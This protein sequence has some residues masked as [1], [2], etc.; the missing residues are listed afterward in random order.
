MMENRFSWLKKLSG[1]KLGII[2]IALIIIVALGIFV[3]AINSGGEDVIGVVEIH[4]VSRGDIELTIHASGIIAPIERREITALVGGNIIYSPFDEGDTVR[5]GDV[6]FR[7][8]DTDARLLAQRMA[9]G[10]EGAALQAQVTAQNVGRL[11]I[12]APATGI[13]S[14]FN[15]N[16]GDPVMGQIGTI[17]DTQNLRVRIPFHA[18]DAEHIRA[19][20]SAVVSSAQFMASINGT[21]TNVL[22]SS[23]MGG[24]MR[25]VEI[26]LINPGALETEMSVGA[27]VLTAN[28]NVMAAGSGRLIPGATA[29]V[30]A[31]Q[32]GNVERVYVSEGQL[33]TRGQV[34]VQLYNIE[35]TNMQNAGN[36][37]VRESQL[38]LEAQHRTLEN[39]VVTSPIDGT[40]ISKN[41][42]AGDN[43]GMGMQEVLMVVA[44]TTKM[45]MMI[46]VDEIEITQVRLG[47]SV[48]VT[49]EPLPGQ[50]FN[51]EITSI[52]GEGV[53]FN[54]ITLFPIEITISEP[55]DLIPGMSADAYIVM[56]DRSN[57]LLL[58]SN[59]IS[60]TG[61]NT[62]VLL[63][64]AS[65]K[66]DVD[67]HALDVPQ[68]T[69]IPVG[70]GIRQIRVGMNDGNLVEIL[71]GLS[72][73]DVVGITSRTRI[74]LT[75]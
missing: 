28:G 4:T 6:L 52:A 61:E 38:A 50:R 65:G 46:A 37:A 34:L 3:V 57:V 26:T 5:A 73:G 31:Q 40:V 13:L 16:V 9:T 60:G 22:N 56:E 14:N 19:G 35:L 63:R 71:D 41:R 54:G 11:T 24:M 43:V 68:G 44:N 30:Q 2:S 27:T 66:T 20:D 53:F 42:N 62:T 29:I 64:G 75:D 47:Q 25:D 32:P 49:A 36:L 7:I 45:E 55:G 67:G 23:T 72:E 8:D 59:F 69:Q 1:K 18:A 74:L 17:T 58:P 12:T 33:V 48:I 10:V 39:F 21:V 51:G 15:I 70:Y